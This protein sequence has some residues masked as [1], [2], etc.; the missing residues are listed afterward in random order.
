MAEPIPIPAF[1]RQAIDRFETMG[2][3][4]DMRKV[5]VGHEFGC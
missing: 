1:P 5:V 2:E 4:E 3:H